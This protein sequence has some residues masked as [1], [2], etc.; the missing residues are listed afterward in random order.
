MVASAAQANGSSEGAPAGSDQMRVTKRRLSVGEAIAYAIVPKSMSMQHSF[1]HAITPNLGVQFKTDCRS[2]GTSASVSLTTEVE[3]DKDKITSYVFSLR[4][5]V[6]GLKSAFVHQR[7]LSPL[8]KLRQKWTLLSGGQIL[9]KV[10]YTLIRKLSTLTELQNSLAWSLYDYGH[11]KTT[12]ERTSESGQQSLNT[13]ITSEGLNFS[14]Y[15]VALLHYGGAETRDPK[16]PAARGKVQYSLNCSPF[17]GQT[18]VGFE[19]WYF[20]TPL[21]QF[22]LS[23]MSVVPYSFSPVAPPFFLVESSQFAV[24][25]QVSLLYARGKHRISVPIIF[26]MSTNVRNAVLW[27]TIPLT[28]YRFARLLY[29]PYSNA[30]VARYYLTERK[31]HLAEM[32]ISRQRA[33]L[34]QHALELCVLRGRAEEDAKGGLV[35]INGQ[36]GVLESI[37]QDP[38]KP[39]PSLLEEDGLRRRR[40]WLSTLVSTVAV[41]IVRFF[42]EKKEEKATGSRFGSSDELDVLDP[43]AGEDVPLTIDVTLALQNMVR[44]SALILPAGSKSKLVGFCDPDPYTPEAKQLKIVYWFNKKRHAVIFN[45]EDSVVLPQRD[46][47]VAL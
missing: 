20:Y 26:F 47:L 28:L 24:V 15:S 10:E 25:N 40:P 3:Y 13:F 8:W 23:F 43:L 41:K 16:I 27:L 35:I 37:Y 5:A 32:D 36:Y 17:T 19:A 1:Q 29:R 39:Q 46:H 21:Q 11:F 44:D 31:K 34:E 18:H 9:Q 30:K 4:T 14:A 42:L 2:K 22:G 12:I 7:V 38:C 33:L 6:T 45:D